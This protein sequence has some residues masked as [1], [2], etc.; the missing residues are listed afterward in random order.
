[1]FAT[2]CFVWIKSRAVFIYF[3][4][5]EHAR[6]KRV[7]ADT[8]PYVLLAI[9]G[10]STILFLLEAQGNVVFLIYKNNAK[11]LSTSRKQLQNMLYD[12]K[13]C[14]RNTEGDQHVENLTYIV[15]VVP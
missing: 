9:K 1:M 5:I 7:R 12:N 8:D 11:L 15:H 10:F 14:Y 2:S 13:N 6:Y 3:S 4:G